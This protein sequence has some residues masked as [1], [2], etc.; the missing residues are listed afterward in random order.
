M[1]SHHCLASFTHCTALQDKENKEKPAVEA[2]KSPARD[3]SPPP[4]KLH[5]TKLT[6]NVTAEHVEEIFGVYG[7]LVSCS[8]AID[9]KVQLPKGYA[10]VEFATA[11]EA[12]RAKEYMDGAQLDG[13]VL[14]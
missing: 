3:K 8:L 10:E 9:P 7:T 5:V 14:Q 2:R 12:E 13:N 1:M 4:T 11:E 6:R